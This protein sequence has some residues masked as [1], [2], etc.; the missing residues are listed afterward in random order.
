MVL[1]KSIVNSV[2]RKN[3]CSDSII[4]PKLKVEL[5]S[6]LIV[7]VYMAALKFVGDWVEEFYDKIEEILEKAGLVR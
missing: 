5:V 7:Q 6:I 4:V 2:V 1:Y 3:V